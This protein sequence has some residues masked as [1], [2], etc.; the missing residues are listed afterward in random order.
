VRTINS[1]F[2]L[3]IHRVCARWIS[4]YAFNKSPTV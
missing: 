3:L 4:V 1:R 2:P